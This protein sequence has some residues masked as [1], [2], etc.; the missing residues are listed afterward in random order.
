MKKRIFS[1]I[2]AAFMLM[3]VF[4]T[5]CSTTTATDGADDGEV[6][7]EDDI[8]ARSSETVVLTLT[9]KEGTTD[10]AIAAVQ[11]A[12]NRITMQRFKTQVILRFYD[13]DEYNEKIDEL[14]AQIAIDESQKENEDESK[15]AEQAESKR[16]AAIERL[17]DKD[18]PEK[19]DEGVIKLFNQEF[20]PRETE[21]VTTVEFYETDLNILG[22]SVQKYPAAT[23][24]QLDI[25]LIMGMENLT[26][27]VQDEKYA[28]DDEPFLVA[29]DEWL[30]LDSK[31]LYQYINPTVLLGGKVGSS[32]YAIPT[33]RQIASEYKYLV[34]DKELVEKYGIDEAKIKTL[35][36]SEMVRFLKQIKANETDVAPMLAREEEAP[37]IV[38]LFPGEDTIFGTYVSNTAVAGFKAPPKNL[39]TAW[40]YTDHYI[41]MEQYERHGYFAENPTEDTRFGVAV[42]T[43]DESFP[44]TMD[45][46]KYIVKVLEKPI[47]TSETTGEYM[48]GISKYSENP[49]RCME[50]ITFL[51]TNT[52]FRNLLQYGIENENYKIDEDTGRLIR[53]NNDYMMDIYATGNAFIAYPEEDMELDVWEIAKTTNLSTVISP[54]LGFIFEN[55]NNVEVIEAVK[56]LSE[57][58]LKRVAEFVPED[59]RV[60][61]LDEY[62]KEITDRT[63][64]LAELNAQL[65]DIKSVYAKYESQVN[66]LNATVEAKQEILADAVVAHTPFANKITSAQTK[67]TSIDSKINSAQQEEEPD[68]EKIAQLQTEREGL[69][70]DYNAAVEEG[71]PTQAAIDAAK[72]EVSNA[73]QALNDYLAQEVPGRFTG[74]G[75]EQKPMTV[76]DAQTLVSATER[77]IRTTENKITTAKNNTAK[78]QY[79]TEDEYDAVIK[80]VYDDFFD[81]LEEELQ[82]DPNYVA[83]MN[84][85]SENSVVVIYDMWYTQMYAAS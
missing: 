23:E 50:L 39:L 14:V 61:R 11:E 36:D 4:M 49:D 28:T 1:L 71:K 21:E 13:E 40:Q 43:G 57:D 64:D 10:E 45:E 73:Q 47:A 80:R 19:K 12:I 53:L 17:M 24:S 59:E 18:R 60:K 65:T 20:I 27:Y 3:S 69:V 55:E 83:F 62:A 84:E 8:T 37:G 35:T 41:Y 74:E 7:E 68:E 56:K 46:D 31:E 30:A 22:G 79:N 70:N 75:E 44:E 9:K 25:F 26:K 29:M 32:T 76:K 63:A 78:L 48:L 2:M 81:S 42:M 15:K 5:S 72:A 67:I 66:A 38:G 54:Y 52:E 82:L 58:M 16:L 77:Q 6:I 51:N 85:E 33:N 34:L